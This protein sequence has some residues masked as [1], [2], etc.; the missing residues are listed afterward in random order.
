MAPYWYISGF[1]LLISIVEILLKKDERTTHILTYLLCIA[2]ATLV[3]F[4]GIRGLGT[5][6]DDYQYRSFFADFINR[7]QV[8]GFAETVAFFRYEPLIFVLAYLTSLVSHNADIFLFI[9]CLLAVAVNAVF[10]KKMSPYP[11]LALAL[12]SAHIFINKDMNQIRFGLS[13]ALFLGVIWYIYLKRYWM[14]LAFTLLSFFSHNTAVM[15]VTIV[16]F[17]FIR[18]SRWWP[19]AI[20]LLSIPASK[21]G[22]TSFISLISA[23]M[24][25]L[26]ER[27]EGYSNET[28]NTGEGSIF[29]VSNLK[30]IMLVFIFVYFLLSNE[31]K[32]YNYQQY[33]L[34][35]LLVLTFAI[36]GGI[37]I[38][39][40]N[41]SS[42]ARLSNYL[43]Q[44]EPIILASLV[45]QVR[46]ILKPAMF[47]MFAFFLVYYLYYNTISL[48]QAVVGYEVAQE[49]KLFH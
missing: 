29:S 14:A 48:K 20:I 9:F 27:A 13:S 46:P 28:S 4:G 31:I 40:Y 8:N 32:K 18:D 11:I 22:G 19:V 30:N 10:F 36:G 41:Y 34:N 12:Y 33:R 35:Y 7:I 37:R 49:F 45:Y 25:S 39:F 21:V 16:P 24:G 42:G 3:V 5:G 43:L 47:A 17:L 23:H 2:A 38:F 44:V 6:M 15:V 1:L 26:G